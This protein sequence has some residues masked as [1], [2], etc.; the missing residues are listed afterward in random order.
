MVKDTSWSDKLEGLDDAVLPFQVDAL[1]IR[2]R[3]VRLGP[4]LDAVLAHHNYPAPV[5]R[6]LGEAV[7]LTAL[8]GSSL[9]FDG[10]FILQTQTDG[11]VDMVVVDFVSP[12]KIRAYARFDAEALAQAEGANH[13]TPAA[14]LGRGHLAMTID[15]GLSANRYQGI[16]ALDGE[17]LEAAA[18]QYFQQSEQ[19]PTRVRLAVGEEMRAGGAPSSWRAGG[20]LAQ[21]LPEDSRRTAQADLH[22]GDAPEGSAAPSVGED[23]A[24]VEAQSLVGTLEDVELIDRDLSSERLLYRLFHE[25]G[26]RV[27]EPVAMR[28]HCTC[29]RDRVKGVLASFEES[30]RREMVQE[31][32]TVGV[33]CEFCGRTYSFSAEEVVG[34]SEA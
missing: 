24:W 10:R 5:K 2:G 22:P 8:L 33:T 23:D 14:L 28:A 20:L 18:H 4:A 15:Q 29:N 32:G 7:A 3:T 13:V 17:G 21:F 34:H 19:I 6:V 27:F 30:E 26:V 1:D 11:P 9:K 16:V 25:R 31:D 12:D